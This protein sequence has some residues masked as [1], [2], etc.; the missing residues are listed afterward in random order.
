[1][2]ANLRLIDGL[3]SDAGRIV[4]KEKESNGW[5][6]LSTLKEPYRVE[7]KKTMGYE[8]AEQLEW[9]M[10]DAIIY[11]TGGGTGLLG[12]WKA[13]QEMETLGWIKGEKPRMISVQSSGC[14]PVAKAFEEGKD[15]IE[16]PF[17]NASTI[18]S[19]LRVPLPYA[20]EQILKVIRESDGLALS[21]DDSEILTAMKTMAKLEGISVCPEGAATLAGL[22]HLVSQKLVDQ[23]D[24]IL[25]YNTGSG[26]KYLD[27]ISD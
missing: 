19:G 7:G 16:T 10:P 23:S 22:N 5:F 1:M 2:G 3:I 8:I 4:A 25:L 24:R 15:S 27:L 6:E 13:F 12:M 26:L 11:P 17:P 18:A 14:S 9:E 20:S 21:V